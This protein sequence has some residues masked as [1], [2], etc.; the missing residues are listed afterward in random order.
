MQNPKL[1]IIATKYNQFWIKS[2]HDTKNHI[3]IPTDLFQPVIFHKGWY[4]LKGSQTKALAWAVTTGIACGQGWEKTIN[5]QGDLYPDDDGLIICCNTSKYPGTSRLCFK[6]HRL[7]HH[8]MDRW[9]WWTEPIPAQ[10]TLSHEKVLSK[11]TWVKA[12]A[13]SSILSLC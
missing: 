5:I 8:E 6:S 3:Q 12:T 13:L 2:R 1:K 4:N 9:D 11:D 7:T 10:R